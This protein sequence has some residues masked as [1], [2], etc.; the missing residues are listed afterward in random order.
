MHKRTAQRWRLSVIMMAGIF[1]ALGSFWL[2]QMMENQGA[3]LG[4]DALRNEPDYIVEKFSFVRMSPAGQPQYLIS[5][6]KLTHR[7]LDDSADIELPLVKSVAPGKPPM[8][9]DANRARI[10]HGNTQIHLIGDVDIERKGSASVEPMKLETEQLLI[11]PDED[12]METDGEVFMRLGSATV[13]GTGMKADNAA[14]RLHLN[15]NGHI[16]YPPK[17][18]R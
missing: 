7:P 1:L 14:Q 4:A 17:T 11:L 16:V 6:A 13:R 3:A 8:T 5:G 15:S 2:A 10:D 18:P 12:R 9:I